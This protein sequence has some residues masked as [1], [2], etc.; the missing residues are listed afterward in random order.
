[1]KAPDIFKMEDFETKRAKF[2]SFAREEAKKEKD[3]VF[4]QELVDTLENPSEALS[5]WTD[6]V[7]RWTQENEREN[8]YKALQQF[9]QT[10]TEDEAID[11]ICLRY[12]VKRQVIQ[13]EDKNAVPP[14]P[15]IMESN[16]SMLLRYALAP[17]GL[18]TT[19]TRMGYKFHSLN[20]GHRPHITV[21][22]ISETEIVMRFKFSTELQHLRPKDAE[23]R[24]P[25]K[26]SGKIDNY[27]LGWANDGTPS[28]E[29]IDAVHHYIT[30]P[31]I[32]QETDDVTTKAAKIKRYKIRLR[33]TEHNEPTKLIDRPNFEKAL[34]QYAKD[35]HRLGH[36]VLCSV[37]D[38]IAHNHKART[39]EILEP[40]ANVDCDWN[41]A[42]FCESVEVI[43][44]E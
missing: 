12:D 21:E 18:S 35:N 16:E 29:L 14:K 38:Q 4:A 25:E 32:A 36:D 19:G 9:A 8:N 42:A 28:G 31:D 41:E 24:T 15:L 40:T 39:V 30:R 43:Y 20:V 6:L 26:N 3:F 33:V 1:M 11:L 27:I 13:E 44:D 22:S 7:I 5:W 37:L 2:L 34:R 17:H 10:A 23:A